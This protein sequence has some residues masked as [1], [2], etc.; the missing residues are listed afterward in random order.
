MLHDPYIGDQYYFS[1]L[2]NEKYHIECGINFMVFSNKIYNV[3]PPMIQPLKKSGEWNNVK[4]IHCHN[5]HRNFLIRSY[6]RILN[7]ISREP[8]Y[9]KIR[10]VFIGNK[11]TKRDE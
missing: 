2:I 4:I 5:L 9:Q 1:N 10:K 6:L 7:K 8:L 11:L 3:R